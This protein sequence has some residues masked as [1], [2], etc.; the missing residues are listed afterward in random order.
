MAVFQKPGRNTDEVE[1]GK[2]LDLSPEDVQE[3]TEDEW[4]ANDR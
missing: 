4:Y 2:P 3:I 1:S